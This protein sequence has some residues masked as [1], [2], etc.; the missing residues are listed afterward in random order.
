[1]KI[2]ELSKEL[3][4]TNKEVI[5][6]LKSN[7]FKISSHNQNATNEMAELATDHF[8]TVTPEKAEEPAVEKTSKVPPRPLPVKETKKFQPDDQ[9]L[10]RSAVP[11][12]LVG[13]SMDKQRLYVWNHFGDYEYVTYRDLQGMRRTNLIKKAK[14]IIEDADLCEQWKYDLGDAY[15]M[16]LGVEY[17]EEFFDMPDDKFEK[18][19][20]EAPGTFKDVIKFTAL[21]MIRNENYPSIQK[22]SII[23]SVLGTG[24]KEF[25]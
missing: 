7:G 13:L 15:K 4:V 1:M 17:P 6:F 22:L 19:L 8:K 12:K 24:I 9:I 5:D 18:A 23:D 14:I 21:D 25:I 11:W 2:N 10:C 3:G 20:R 16:Y